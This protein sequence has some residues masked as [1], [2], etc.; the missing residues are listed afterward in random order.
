MKVDAKIS[1]DRLY[2]SE[3]SYG[4]SPLVLFA[5]FNAPFPAT[6]FPREFI[7]FWVNDILDF[8]VITSLN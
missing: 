8:E 1:P 2:C 7:I 6:L 5:A 4:F 3:T